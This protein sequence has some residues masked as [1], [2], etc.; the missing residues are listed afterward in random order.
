MQLR[1]VTLRYE[2]ADEFGASYSH[3]SAASTDGAAPTGPRPRAA[4][5]ARGARDI[6]LDVPAGRTVALVG[7]H[8]LGQDEPRGA[9]LAAV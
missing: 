9:D 1:D 3:A 4:G 7:R 5:S 6:D 8:R 2:D